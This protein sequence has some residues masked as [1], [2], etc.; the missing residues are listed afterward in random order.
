MYRLLCEG[1]DADETGAGYLGLSQSHKR[2]GRD[3][4]LDA[5][6]DLVFHTSLEILPMIILALVIFGVG[7]LAGIL[8]AHLRVSPLDALPVPTPVTLAMTSIHGHVPKVT[9]IVAH[10][11]TPAVAFDTQGVCATECGFGSVVRVRASKARPAPPWFDA[12]RGFGATL[13]A[14]IRAVLTESHSVAQA[15]SHGRS[16]A[17]PDFQEFDSSRIRP[18]RQPRL[19]GDQHEQCGVDRQTV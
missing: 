19:P 13:L 8:V 7:A 9:S 16:Q 4:G 1:R 2:W 11:S 12:T 10:A 17:A 6:P 3:Q 15:P 18:I 5:G 14:R